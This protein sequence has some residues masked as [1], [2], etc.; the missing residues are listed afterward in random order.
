MNVLRLLFK[1]FQ[2]CTGFYF[3]YSF[4]LVWS[5][6]TV[7][8]EKCFL[9]DFYVI[10]TVKFLHDLDLVNTKLIK[11]IYLSPNDSPSETM[12]DDFYFILKALFVIKIFNFL[13][14][15]LPLFFSVS[16]IALKLDPRSVL[17]FIT[18]STV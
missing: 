5:N 16:D 13:Y 3:L 14:F 6:W 17:K 12:K 9:F 2:V 7:D 15:H 1:E 11:Y 4:I 10:L 8:A 18:S